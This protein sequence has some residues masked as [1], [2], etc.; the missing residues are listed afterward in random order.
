MK[1][2]FKWSGGK[3]KELIYIKKYI[4][5]NY[6]VYYE[7][8]LGAGALLFDLMPE[9]A[10]V[11]DSFQ[12]LINFF[13]VLKNSKEPFV[14]KINNLAKEYNLSVQNTNSKEEQQKVADKYYYWYRDN[15][16]DNDFDN[17]IKFYMLRQL[18]FAGM[19][20]FDKNGNFNIPYGWYKTLKTININQDLNKIEFK[21]CNWQE[22]IQNANL[23]DFVF[24]DPPYTRK[25]QKYHP[26]GT[27]GKDEHIVLAEWF[28][29]KQ[30]RA[31][32]VINKDEFT[33]SLYKEF[34]VE[35][36]SKKYSIRYRK[37]RMKEKDTNAIHFVAKNY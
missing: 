9:K 12:D 21:C 14:N 6:D 13:N 2:L 18:S 11:G 28:V 32:I 7:P 27:F 1:P 35:E 37:D 3:S 16:F 8:F 22:T 26:N 23:E 25:F 30:S 17:A 34:I 36:Y 19:L 33:S 29:S 24:L 20:R 31:L 5:K 15:A 10:I 4:P